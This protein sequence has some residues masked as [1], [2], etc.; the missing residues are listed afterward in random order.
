MLVEPHLT[1]IAAPL[2]SLGSAAV[3]RLLKNRPSERL[4]ASKPVVLPARFVIRGS[5]GPG[6]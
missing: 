3:A 6:H 5:T 4:E 1:T 2:V